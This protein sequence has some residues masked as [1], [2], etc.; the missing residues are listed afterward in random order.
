[1][2]FRHD[3]YEYGND[4]SIRKLNGFLC[5]LSN[6]MAREKTR[7]HLGLCRCTSKRILQYVASQRSSSEAHMKYGPLAFWKTKRKLFIAPVFLSCL[8]YRI[9]LSL[10]A[11][12]MQRSWV[13][14][15][16]ALSEIIISICLYVC[17]SRDLT[18]DLRSSD[19]LY[20]GSPMDIRG[21]DVED[22][23]YPT[24]LRPDCR[25]VFI[26]PFTNHRMHVSVFF[27]KSI[28]SIHTE[29]AA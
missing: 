13:A 19:R 1:M 16:E 3:P 8:K 17:R 20:V 23:G 26:N 9:R 4:L 21:D 15:V 24:C 6:A 12:C 25:S 28:M 29:T 10:R 18:A 11:S 5:T 7:G 2:Y 22:I 14:S 27:M